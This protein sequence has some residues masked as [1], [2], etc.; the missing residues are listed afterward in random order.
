M[1]I[2]DIR[3]FPPLAVARL[4][5]SPEPL[6]NYDLEIRDAVSPRTIVPAESLV[7]DVD[8]NITRRKSAGPVQFRDAKGLI[9]PVAPFFELHAQLDDCSDW[10]P[11]TPELL[12]QNGFELESVKW[13]AHLGNIKVERRTG[14]PHDRMEAIVEAFNDHTA[15]LV[16]GTCKN[17]IDGESVP[18]GHVQ[19]ARSEEDFPGLR[20]RFTPA[21]GKVYG[22]KSDVED[23]NVVRVVYDPAKGC[24]PGYRE[25]G[26]P[27]NTY[28]GRRLTNPAQIFAGYDTPDDHISY[29]YIDDECDGVI[30]VQIEGTGLSAFA[31]VAAGPPTFAPDSKPVRTVADELEQVLRGPDAEANDEELAAVRDTVRRALETVRLMNTGQL[32]KG[33]RTRGVGM[34]RMDYLDVGRKSDPIFDPMVAESLAIRSRHERVLLALE[35]GALAWFARILRDY[36]KVGDLT[37]EGRRKMPG[38]MRSADG[39]HLALTRRQVSK[40]KAVADYIV[41]TGAKPAVQQSQAAG[42]A[43]KPLNLSAQLAFEAAGNPP[44]SRPDTAISNAF[45]GLEMDIRNVWKRILEG[46]VLHESLNFVLEVERE[47]LKPL[48]GMFIMKIAGIELTAPVTG[49]NADGITG[50]LKDAYGNDRMALEWSNALA[51]ILHEYK[52]K[53]VHCVFQSLDGKQQHDKDLTVRHFFEHGTAVIARAIAQPGALT[54]SLCAP[55]QNDYRECSC[56]YWAANRPDY[57][58]VEPR[59]DGTS[60]GQNW[61]QRDRTF[62]TPKVYINDDWQDERLLTHSDL[63]QNWEKALRFVIGNE[64]EPPIA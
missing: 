18:L 64:D 8:G 45:P 3:L 58:N 36:D 5:S 56:F 19:Y 41:K 35:S 13:S 11:L 49:P 21:H 60:A 15:H 33:G 14:N 46:L 29:G 20:I 48:K 26:S 23:P 24:W 25:P 55:W 7:L 16:T 57:V 6:E 61:M 50:P 9:K 39:R 59:A 53:S 52:G 27:P 17:F 51:D 4:G 30:E 31:R 47:D 40:I 28:E 63:V 2:K 38:M 42:P 37:D 1:A 32:N 22:S 62:D 43:I 12:R 10:V 54:E 44:N 34:A